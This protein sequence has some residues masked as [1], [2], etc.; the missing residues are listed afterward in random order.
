MIEKSLPG[1][2]DF[3]AEKSPNVRFI[4]G[5]PHLHFHSTSSAENVFRTLARFSFLR[6][7]DLSDLQLPE[8]TQNG[9]LIVELLQSVGPNLLVFRPPDFLSIRR[10]VLH[11]P[12]FG[13]SEVA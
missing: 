12:A 5:L 3:F 1:A 2:L 7:L 9:H 11:F 4:L 6:M 13:K 8:N 10:F